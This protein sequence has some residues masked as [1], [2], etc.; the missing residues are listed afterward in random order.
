MIANWTALDH[1]VCIALVFARSQLTIGSC[2][3]VRASCITTVNAYDLFR[4]AVMI[5]PLRA[6]NKLV[7]ADAARLL[8]SMKGDAVRDLP[9]ALQPDR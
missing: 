7:T 5:M 2:S 8:P 6:R 1:Q 3:L 9:I 4:S